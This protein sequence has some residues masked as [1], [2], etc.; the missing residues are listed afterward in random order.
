MVMSSAFDAAFDVIKMSHLSATYGVALFNEVI[1]KAHYDGELRK[2]LEDYLDMSLAEIAA[3]PPD[4]KEYAFN[5]I[6]QNMARNQGYINP[7]DK[8]PLAQPPKATENP[9][10]EAPMPE[11]PEPMQKAFRALLDHHFFL[12]KAL[13]EQQMF[14]ERS[15][16]EITGGA[17]DFEFN[18]E[19]APEIDRFGARSMGTV[20]P[21]IRGMLQRNR[22]N[23][24]QTAGLYPNL[25]LDLGADEQRMIAR[26]F[27]D[28]GEPQ[29]P[30]EQAAHYL[31]GQSIA[32]GPEF[33]RREYD[34]QKA[35][36]VM[37]SV[38]DKE[39]GMTPGV[40]YGDYRRDVPNYLETAHDG[41]ARPMGGLPAHV[42]E[43]PTPEERELYG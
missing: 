11:E 10:G 12:N 41:G 18:Y 16:R 29:S 15:P 21:A 37:Q 22:E 24:H 27:R 23:F 9:Q 20:H 33:N 43:Y 5:L 34:R 14:V 38:V 25:N 2:R 1:A 4:E 7:E 8:T 17:E 32:Q 19:R 42:V 3:L 35:H 40:D 13:P 39:R 36:E 30:E 6:Q 28:R 26:P 31:A